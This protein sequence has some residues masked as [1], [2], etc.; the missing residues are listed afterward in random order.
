LPP[1]K[2]STKGV[3]KTAPPLDSYVDLNG[4]QVPL[5]QGKT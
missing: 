3:G 5:G 4:Y 2:N 1:G